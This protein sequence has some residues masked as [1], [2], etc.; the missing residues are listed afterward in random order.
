MLNFCLF[1][2]FLLDFMAIANH[3][4][5]KLNPQKEQTI[6]CPFI[7]NPN[8]ILLYSSEDASLSRRVSQNGMHHQRNS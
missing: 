3:C 6:K 4:I 2:F 5:N 8:T 7:S 1:F